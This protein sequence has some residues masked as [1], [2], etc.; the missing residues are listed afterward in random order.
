M[1]LYLEQ[2]PS[3]K[4]FDEPLDEGKFVFECTLAGNLQAFTTCRLHSHDQETVQCIGLAFFLEILL[5]V[6]K[7]TVHP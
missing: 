4:H 6:T 1:Q 7:Y 5:H 2:V 3:Y